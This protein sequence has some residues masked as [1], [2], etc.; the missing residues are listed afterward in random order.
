MKKLATPFLAVIF[1]LAGCSGSEPLTFDLAH[2]MEPPAQPFQISGAAVD[3]GGV[4]AVGMWTDES[5][6]TMEGADLDFGGFADIFDTA[7]ETQSAAEAKGTKIFEC[8]DGSGMITI[9]EHTLID[10][11][12]LDPADFGSGTTDWGT[13]TIEGTGDYAS[14]TGSGKVI[15]VWDEMQMHF[16]GEVEV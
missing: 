8:G 3:D 5:M 4:C 13:W 1:I 16:V 15:T 9:N 7:V 2:P 11:A 6:Q 14:L 12:V 10:F